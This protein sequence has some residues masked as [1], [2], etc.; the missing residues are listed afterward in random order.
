M[1]AVENLPEYI[2]EQI[3]TLDDTARLG[4]LN[5][6]LREVYYKIQFSISL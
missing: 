4:D 3:K 5:L 1:V 6:P 2:L